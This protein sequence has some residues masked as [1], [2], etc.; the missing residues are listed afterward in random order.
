[1]AIFHNE[2]KLN[3]KLDNHKKPEATPISDGDSGPDQLDE[4]RTLKKIMKRRKSAENLTSGRKA[5]R[6]NF[7]T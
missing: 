7:R 6:S 3:T 4:K 2:A 1:M 5:I